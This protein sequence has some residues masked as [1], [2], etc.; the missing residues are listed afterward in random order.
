[1]KRVCI[2]FISNTILFD[3]YFDTTANEL[4]LVGIP[5][6]YNNTIASHF[7]SEFEPFIML[8]TLLSNKIV[9]QLKSLI[10]N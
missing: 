6:H 10:Y 5:R 1:M 8:M 2:Y 3:I 9:K 4:L 7:L